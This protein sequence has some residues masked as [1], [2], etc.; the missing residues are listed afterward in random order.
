MKRCSRFFCASRIPCAF[1]S[2]YVCLDA[3]SWSFCS[4]SPSLTATA[5]V[6]SLSHTMTS[7]WSADVALVVR[8][9]TKQPSWRA[10]ARACTPTARFLISRLRL[11]IV[12][13]S[14]CYT[15]V[16]TWFTELCLPGWIRIHRARCAALVTRN[17]RILAHIWETRHRLALF[18]WS[19]HSKNTYRLLAS[20]YA[21]QEVIGGYEAE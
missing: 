13:L 11:P 6:V 3:G 7:Q 2:M 20:A 1:L 12:R 8:S 5:P 18:N 16:S 14:N 10:R 19:H 15:M 9:R 4:W 17:K 21:W